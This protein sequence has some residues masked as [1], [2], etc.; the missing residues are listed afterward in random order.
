MQKFKCWVSYNASGVKRL[1]EHWSFVVCY[2]L[3]GFSSKIILFCRCGNMAEL[4]G[5][6]YL[7]FFCK[8]Q[9][10]TCDFEKSQL[11]IDSSPPFLCAFFQFILPIW[12]LSISFYL[13]IS[14]TVVDCKL[15]LCHFL[16]PPIFCEWF[17][18]LSVHV[19]YA[20]R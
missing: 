15:V 6:I 11:T 18:E 19:L 4:P 16:F 2:K 17:Y 1:L 5:L 10:N 13:I 20:S 3:L 7:S 8:I 14:D 9:S 12:I